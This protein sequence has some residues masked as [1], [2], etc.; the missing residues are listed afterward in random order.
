MA[1]EPC[2]SGH[3]LELLLPMIACW[4][5]LHTH[6]A[7]IKQKLIASVPHCIVIGPTKTILKMAILMSTCS[8][9]LGKHIWNVDRRPSLLP[10]SLVGTTDRSDEAVSQ[11]WLGCF[12][13]FGSE[14]G[15]ESGSTPIVSSVGHCQTSHCW[16]LRGWLV[17]CKLPVWWLELTYWSTPSILLLA[18]TSYSTQVGKAAFI[19]GKWKTLLEFYCCYKNKAMWM[20]RL[21]SWC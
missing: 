7:F 5:R 13:A 18:E 8:L 10:F 21:P 20:V 14:W 3:L 15:L 19:Y 4:E 2:S 9:M 12:P 6:S 1:D 17:A 11:N 16:W